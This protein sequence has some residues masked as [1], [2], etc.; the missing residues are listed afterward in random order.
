[1]Q[2]SEKNGF[3]IKNFGNDSLEKDFSL[4]RNLFIFNL[5]SV[6]SVV[7]YDNT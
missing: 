3:P 4:S 1:M 7:N 5:F 6:F 2:F